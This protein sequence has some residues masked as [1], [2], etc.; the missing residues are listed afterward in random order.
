MRR[1]H[2]PPTLVVITPTSIMPEPPPLSIEELM[3]KIPTG[4]SIHR[5]AD[6]MN[7]YWEYR[8]NGHR[9]SGAMKLR[10]LLEMEFDRRKR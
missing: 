4:G 9:V 3:C 8:M 5:S 7:V 2:L 6:G 1:T 10:L